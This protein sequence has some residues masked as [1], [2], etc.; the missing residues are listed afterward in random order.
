[1]CV[2]DFYILYIHSFI[3]KTP[4]KYTISYYIWKLR[5]V[6]TFTRCRT[7]TWDITIISRISYIEHISTLGISHYTI[8]FVRNIFIVARNFSLHFTLCARESY[9]IPNMFFICSSN[10]IPKIKQKK[11]FLLNQNKY[12][13]LKQENIYETT[14]I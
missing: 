10:L 11:T 7:N 3:L 9:K 12:K 8:V 13:C 14:L 4:D 6:F 1:M 2:G 5:A